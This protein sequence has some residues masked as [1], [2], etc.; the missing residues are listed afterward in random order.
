V[1]PPGSFDGSPVAEC[2]AGSVVVGTGFNGPFNAVGG[3]VKAYGTF[4]GGFFANESSITL[5]GNVEAICAMVGSARASAS[6]SAA[7][8]EYQ[9]DLAEA[10]RLASAR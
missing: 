7:R 8:S 3:F 10:E 9:D 1:L 5:E 2:P 6:V 4:V